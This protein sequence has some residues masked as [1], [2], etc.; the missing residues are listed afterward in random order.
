MAPAS[1]GDFREVVYDYFLERHIALKPDW[2]DAALSY[3][4]L[5][6]KPTSVNAVCA[7]IFEQWRYADI[8]K[9]TYPTLRPIHNNHFHFE[10]NSVLQIVSCI[11]IATPAL[12]Q[13]R[14]CTSSS[15]DNAEFSSAPAAEREETSKYEP[16]VKR[17]LKL[18]LS[19]GESQIEAIEYKPIPW[20]KPTIFPGSKLLFTK[21]IDCR[22]GILMLTP[23]NC[24][25]LGGQVA[26]LFPT[27]LLTSILATKLNKKLKVSSGALPNRP[28]KPPSPST[29]LLPPPLAASTPSTSG[30]L[31]I[32]R[33]VNRSVSAPKTYSF[34]MTA[35][36]PIVLNESPRLRPPRSTIPRDNAP[37]TDDEH[38]AMVLSIDDDFTNDAFTFP[39]RQTTE[40]TVVD[41]VPDSG[42]ETVP[43]TP[44]LEDS[45]QNDDLS[46]FLSPEQ[47]E[48][49][50]REQAE[51]SA[52]L[53]SPSAEPPAKKS[54]PMS[55]L[56]STVPEPRPLHDSTNVKSQP[57]PVRKQPSPTP[58]TDDEEEFA[59]STPPIRAQVGQSQPQWK[60]PPKKLTLTK[61]KAP[62]LPQETSQRP[63]RSFF[64]P[65]VNIK[66]EAESDD[67]IMIL[68]PV[69]QE[70]P[71]EPTTSSSFLAN[72][73]STF[74]SASPFVR[75]HEDSKMAAD[76]FV[77]KYMNLSLST[78][79]ASLKFMKYAV[80]SK[81]FDIIA[82]VDTITK[83]L[84]VV[85][86]EWAM[87]LLL[88]DETEENFH[89]VM[90]HSLL[91][92]LIGLTPQEAAAIR[93]SADEKKKR[94]GHRRINSI[95][96]QLARLDLVFTI[97]LFA[98]RA[99][100]T[101]IVC[102]V[103]TVAS[104]LLS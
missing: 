77:Q 28:Q 48:L 52:H 18:T 88:E 39:Q 21:T 3:L 41:L 98:A 94:D 63:M 45:F 25:K 59:K 29:R 75:R 56:N 101:P 73:I 92:E 24:Q 27:N 46:L 2:F 51:L 84:R 99:E 78:I 62:Q 10:G 103:D 61:R 53:L 9:T 49:V 81:R 66:K 65:K 13:F 104:R 15:T 80:G 72:N 35:E 67:D 54:A 50:R 12:T 85:D 8:A 16:K 26:K 89:C 57:P 30:S 90:S 60:P 83:P 38:L 70:P 55:V 93:N 95:K 23:E 102:G 31:N 69:K 37:P 76:P 5:K 97:E 42:N 34:G 79:A 22:R 1:A 40:R 43:E 74:S 44:P 47:L 19:D 4:D 87:D 32:S 17:M 6:A 91:C 96:D 86:G 14:K 71:E 20:L 100:V 68:S 64:E 7:L 58:W 82:M 33:S 11:D 36:N